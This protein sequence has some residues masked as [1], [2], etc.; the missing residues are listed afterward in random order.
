MN[1]NQTHRG[2]WFRLVAL[3]V[4]AFFLAGCS[5][6]SD[7][8]D[9]FDTHQSPSDEEIDTFI[10]S[11]KFRN[12]D[13]QTMYRLAVHYQRRGRHDWAI[14]EFRNILAFEPSFAL[15][16]NGIG[17]SLDHHKKFQLAEKAYRKAL[18]IDPK[19]DCAWN[20][21]GYSVL[22]QGNP[23]DAAVYFKKA[24]ALRDDNPRYHNNLMIAKRQIVDQ[25]LRLEDITAEILRSVHT[26]TGGSAHPVASTPATSTPWAFSND[27]DRVSSSTPSFAHLPM[28]ILTNTPLLVDK[29]SPESTPS[30]NVERV[31]VHPAQEHSGEITFTITPVI[32][33]RSVDH[34][35]I[36]RPDKHS[37]EFLT[38]KS[39][40]N[41]NAANLMVDTQ[42]LDSAIHRL[43]SPPIEVA[44][45]NGVT[46]MA[47]CVKRY[48]S[49]HG[50]SVERA[51]NADHFGYQ[52][53]KL[54]YREG[55]LQEAWAVAKAIPGH[56]V[57]YKRLDPNR[58]HIAV[59][60]V[61]GKD[62]RP[63]HRYF[64]DG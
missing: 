16:Y 37:A 44:N 46:G 21:L 50:F 55:Y 40:S 64:Q 4:S 52:D 56:Q 28:D 47:A 33:V 57:F 48:L 15:A 43:E 60:V 19:L 53:T 20:N 29:P 38:G 26:D 13:P 6:W 1:V 24:I 2:L 5:L 35:P 59:K 58:P 61:L 7:M 62:M 22:M 32:T 9:M 51:S 41:L 39:F 42:E 45:G 11:V 3:L 25:D 49:R 14:N 8:S 12:G 27:K 34:M 30:R 63:H 36:I 23:E 18:E 10:E 31:I 17:V 54:Y